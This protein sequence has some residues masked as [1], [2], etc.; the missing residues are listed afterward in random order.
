LPFL[1]P[2]AVDK[3]V[4]LDGEEPGLDVRPLLKLGEEAKCAQVSL[5]D[6]VFG[7]GLILRE[8]EGG[9]VD[10]RNLWDSNLFKRRF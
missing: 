6:Q 4:I 3:K 7:I 1:L 10:L 2:I 8:V 5:L 9:L